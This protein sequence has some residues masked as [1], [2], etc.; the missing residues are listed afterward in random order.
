MSQGLSFSVVGGIGNWNT[1]SDWTA[2][3]GYYETSPAVPPNLTWV[4]EYIGS[5]T[6]SMSVTGTGNYFGILD[7]S[8][9]ALGTDTFN[10]SG[11]LT[12]AAIGQ[13]N[14]YT[15]LIQSGGEVS[16][17]LGM[18]LT[19]ALVDV[20]GTLDT[21][22]NPLY[23][24]SGASLTIASGG[25]VTTGN[26][27]DVNGGTLSVASGGFLTVGDAVTLSNANLYLGG[28]E[29]IAGGG[30]IT[31]TYSTITVESGATI[32]AYALNLSSTDTLLVYGTLDLTQVNTGDTASGH[33]TI[34][35]GGVVIDPGY[36]ASTGWVIAGGTYESEQSGLSGN[37]S[38]SGT[39]GTL[40]LDNSTNL[41]S[42]DTITG[43]SAGD[44]IVVKGSAAVGSALTS[45]LVNNVLTII[46]GTTTLATVDD[47]T[48]SSTASVYMTGTYTTGEVIVQS[49]QSTYSSG[50]NTLGSPGAP[51]T[52]TNTSTITLTG[53][54]TT[55]AVY[56]SLAGTG[57]YS[58]SNGAT[59]ALDNPTGNDAGQA[60][61]FGANTG[62]SPNM[63]ILDGSTAGFGGAIT[64]FGNGDAID[65]GAS[66]L[67]A[68][69][70]GEGVKLSYASGVLTVTE[71]TSTG[72]TVTS[73]STALTIAGSGLSTASFVALTSTSGIVL[74]T[75]GDQNGQ[76]YAFSIASGTGGFE[77]PANFTGGVAPGDT[78]YTGET[79]SIA[80]GTASVA[81]GGVTDNGVITI[82]SGFVDTGSLSGTGALAIGAAGNATLTGT[83]A[84]GSI[85][86]AG[87]LTLAG[88]D[89]T[90]ISV[91]TGGQITLSGAFTDSAAITGTGS[92]TVAKNI[93]ATLAGGSSIASIID[94]GTLTAAGSLGGAI[95]MQGNTAGTKAVFAGADETTG[96]LNTAL[97]NFGTGDTIV[98]GASNFSLSGAADS[99][100][101]SYNSGTDQLTVTD[102]TSGASAVLNL[103]LASGDSATWVHL[104]STSSG[105]SLTLCFY[106]GTAI[107]T[108]DGTAAVET[109]K[110][111]DLVMTANGTKPVRWVGQSHI[112]TRFADPLKSLPVRI[113]QGALGDG[114]PV[115]DLL[116]SPDHALHI[117]GLLVHASALVGLPGITRETAVP[118]TFTYYHVELASHELL[119][120]EGALAESFVD[121][122]ERMHFHNWDERTAPA[123]AIAE[124]ELPRVKSARQ[125]PA[126][127]RAR[128][129]HAA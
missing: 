14:D 73:A 10:V 81:S 12:G 34:E 46:A 54:T 101:S 53:A 129:A 2:V 87:T 63:L 42:S 55:L 19:S 45:T 126:S 33:N 117:D 115:R 104:A 57:A 39:G 15:M 1:A 50:S 118:E 71:T 102:H 90:A 17:S 97:T 88:T 22:S 16:M 26:D 65:L 48:S 9:T 122:V 110:A 78:L 64:G 89:S 66:V 68:L 106:A 107:A 125:L 43:F 5:N 61:V 124:M 37:F 79:V 76:T 58:L 105:L 70:S 8:G 35:A 94:A 11:T 28:N 74:E 120:A 103:T 41:I 24:G 3:N 23:V 119:F 7:V 93:A 109:L 96:T 77:T 13:F 31:G 99:L 127:L 98:L 36:D 116:V 80:S 69:T 18:T 91:A 100:T 82:S 108:P 121:N 51:A 20:M 6:T 128:L 29:T 21:G 113:T 112:H 62:T 47:V 59:L 60:V 84:L 75:V 30:A 83:T 72:A 114:L 25:H 85:T 44:A 123:H 4:T 92:L 49:G 95:N 67:P 27:L 52:V 40:E 111:G 56:D 38:F 86:D 32:D